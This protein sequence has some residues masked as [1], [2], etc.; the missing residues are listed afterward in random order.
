MTGRGIER[1]RGVS[2]A[3]MGRPLARKCYPRSHRLSAGRPSPQS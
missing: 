1:V 3:L 2:A